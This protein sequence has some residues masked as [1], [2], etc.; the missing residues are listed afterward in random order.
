MFTCLVLLLVGGG[1]GGLPSQGW[2]DSGD[3][4]SL[5]SRSFLLGH[6]ELWLPEVV[7]ALTL[8]AL[9]FGPEEEQVV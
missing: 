4:G 9:G 1:A 5:R 2:K 3:L 8:F 6:Q 7:A